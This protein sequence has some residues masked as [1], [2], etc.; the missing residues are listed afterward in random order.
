MIVPIPPLA[1]LNDLANAINQ[2]NN[3]SQIYL[4][5]DDQGV[6]FTS[7]L[8]NYNNSEAQFG[9]SYTFINGDQEFII[10]LPSYE[11]VNFINK[12]LQTLGSLYVSKLKLWIDGSDKRTKNE[13][14]QKIVSK[15]YGGIVELLENTP[16]DFIITDNSIKCINNSNIET[17]TDIDVQNYFKLC[18]VF[19]ID[20]DKY[21]NDKLIFQHNR[22][23]LKIT[24]DNAADHTEQLLLSLYDNNVFVKGLE[25]NIND[26]STLYYVLVD[27]NANFYVNYMT[28][29]NVPQSYNFYQPTAENVYIS[30]KNGEAN[31]S[32]NLELFE[33][34]YYCSSSNDCPSSNDI[35]NYINS[36]YSISTYEL[37]HN[38][39]P[40]QAGFNWLLDQNNDYW[41]MYNNNISNLSTEWANITGGLTVINNYEINFGNSG[42]NDFYGGTP[43]FSGNTHID[44]N[45][46]KTNA[47]KYYY[48]III[49][50]TSHTSS[51]YDIGLGFANLAYGVYTTADF[52]RLGAGT[53]G[54]LQLYNVFNKSNYGSTAVNIQSM[55][56]ISKPKNIGV[57]INYISPS[58]IKLEFYMYGVLKHSQTIT[59]N[60]SSY[61]SGSLY[62]SFHSYGATGI[63]NIKYLPSTSATMKPAG[64]I[65]VQ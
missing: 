25:L 45:L 55:D 63:Y 8:E 2:A 28:S 35:N 49:N 26:K 57:G 30:S 11:T 4:Y 6:V 18:M 41:A 50:K 53:D 20:V 31:I 24:M 23:K 52:W 36:K 10:N 15:S 46:A 14:L 47:S 51:S 62:P 1:V 44:V 33:L 9:L 37:L 13:Q 7:K 60:Y 64:Y 48:E 5:K 19:K 43:L 65:Y 39:L 17:K 58:E 16:Y 56:F 54:Y 42:R 38:T 27:N 34:L 40:L 59:L 12:P 61:Q 32:S 3:N 21:A 22:F 29:N